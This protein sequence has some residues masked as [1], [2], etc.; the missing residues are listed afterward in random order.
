MVKFRA[1][2]YRGIPYY[3]W[4]VFSSR[5]K[6]NSRIRGVFSRASNLPRVRYE[7]D[8]RAES[9]FPCG[10]LVELVTLY[11]LPFTSAGCL[12]VL[13][14][15]FLGGFVIWVVD[16]PLTGYLLRLE[17]VAPF[18]L[19]DSLPFLVGVE[20]PDSVGCFG[21]TNAFVCLS[22]YRSLQSADI[23]GK[24]RLRLFS[25]SVRISNIPSSFPSS[26]ASAAEIMPTVPVVVGAV[27]LVIF[28]KEFDVAGE[29]DADGSG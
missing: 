8:A 13:V 16:R 14:D 23:S 26:R 3:T 27:G 29:E 2:G 9:F 5:Y 10:I 11:A 24:S 20:E 22:K 7:C 15:D 1:S 28:F 4:N 19:L 21:M 12:W 17:P 18:V 25:R 6:K